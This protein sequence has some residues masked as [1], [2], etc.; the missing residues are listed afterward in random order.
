MPTLAAVSRPPALA[1]GSW[2]SA[3]P[4]YKKLCGICD[5]RQEQPSRLAVDLLTHAALPH[6][7]ACTTQSNLPAMLCLQGT[8]TNR[9]AMEG[10]KRPTSA[11]D[12]ALDWE[13]GVRLG[14]RRKR[15][16]D[17]LDAR[18]QTFATEK[19]RGS[20]AWRRAKRP[21]GARVIG[22]KTS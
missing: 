8:R 9:R 11:R 3:C 15:V 21:R 14:R 17:P 20:G 22:P 19:G 10:G 16:R 7:D 12:L 2:L 13:G 18:C 4:W 6:P 1:D 5:F